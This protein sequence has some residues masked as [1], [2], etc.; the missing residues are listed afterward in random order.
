MVV[1]AA[2]HMRMPA[3]ASRAARSATATPP[4]A[5]FLTGGDSLA[6]QWKHRFP[7]V[8]HGRHVDVFA[9]EGYFVD[10]G[11]ASGCLGEAR[12]GRGGRVGRML[13]RAQ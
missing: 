3:R 12:K 9:P 11:L 5:R 7:R 8:G 4:G 2:A 6:N 10:T 1:V 13:V